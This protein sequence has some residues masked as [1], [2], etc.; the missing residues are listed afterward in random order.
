MIF[1]P[2]LYIAQKLCKK[3]KKFSSWLQPRSETV[4]LLQT[5]NHLHYCKWTS[6]I[7][8]SS[9]DVGDEWFFC[10]ASVGAAP[11][12]SRT[13]SMN[14]LL[15]DPSVLLHCTKSLAGSINLCWGNYHA[16]GMS[17]MYNLPRLVLYLYKAHLQIPAGEGKVSS[18]FIVELRISAASS[19]IQF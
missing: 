15:K 4:G 6:A 11:W 1:A 19:E 12:G 18:G 16:A 10:E 8:P 13:C 17:E 2:L 3:V 5:I 14:G 9:F 7:S